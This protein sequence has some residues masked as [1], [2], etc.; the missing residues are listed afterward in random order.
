MPVSNK[1]LHKLSYLTSVLEYSGPTFFNK[2]IAK[3]LKEHPEAQGVHIFPN[4]YFYPIGSL[5]F[6]LQ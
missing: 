4:T 6:S 3:Y 5:F 1:S 2:T